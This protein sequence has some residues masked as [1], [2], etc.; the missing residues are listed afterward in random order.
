MAVCGM[1]SED[2]E[3]T[4]PNTEDFLAYLVATK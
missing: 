2:C 1:G 4:A 3:D